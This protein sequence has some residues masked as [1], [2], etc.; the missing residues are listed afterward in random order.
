MLFP[1]KENLLK[2]LLASSKLVNH[3]SNG[4]SK[5]GLYWKGP[6][7][8]IQSNLPATLL[9]AL[10]NLNLNTASDPQ[11]LWATWSSVSLPSSQTITF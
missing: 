6:S 2:M 4:E 3:Y 7:K 9:Q 5:N 11:L 8:I 10:H 1:C